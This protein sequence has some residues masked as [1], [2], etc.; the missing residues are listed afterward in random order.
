[1]HVVV[2]IFISIAGIASLALC[3]KFLYKQSDL[4]VTEKKEEGNL[5]QM[6]LKPGE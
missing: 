5:K 4:E 1:M 6:R 2:N 3:Y